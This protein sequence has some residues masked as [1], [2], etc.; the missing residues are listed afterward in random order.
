MVSIK[1]S[2]DTLIF[3][4]K[5]NNTSYPI[6]EAKLMMLIEHYTNEIIIFDRT[7][8]KHEVTVEDKVIQ[9]KGVHKEKD[10]YESECST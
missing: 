2:G 5:L 6:D 8:M 4:D 9:V 3:Q 7:T 1:R 10:V